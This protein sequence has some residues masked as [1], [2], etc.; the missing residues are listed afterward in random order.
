MSFENNVG[1]GEIGCNKQFLLF[2]IVFYLFGELS[3]IFSKFEI[4]C[5]LF[6][7]G[8]VLKFVV[9]ERVKYF[10]SAHVSYPQRFS[11]FTA[12]QSFIDVQI[13]DLTHYQT[14]KFKTGP[15]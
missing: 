3:A 11:Y 5:K 7:F 9:W 1:R 8:R 12:I 6:Q 13:K 14:T 15:N 10:S 2:L 4:V